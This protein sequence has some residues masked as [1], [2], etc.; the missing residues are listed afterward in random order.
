MWCECALFNSRTGLI[1]QNLMLFNEI[2]CL[3]ISEMVPASPCELQSEGI[4]EA[5][6]RCS[7]ILHSSKLCIR[8]K[9]SRFFYV[10]LRRH[11]LSQYVKNF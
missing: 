11:L 8:Q 10:V 3:T 6:K 9:L 5:Q 7:A 2:V 4:F 1:L